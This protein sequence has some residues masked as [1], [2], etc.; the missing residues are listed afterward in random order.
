MRWSARIVAGVA[1]VL[2]AGWL[3]LR[4]QPAPFPPYPAPSAQ[5][6]RAPLPEGL[7][8]PVVRYYRALY[9]GDAV[10]LVETAVLT[11]RGT[12]RFGP[13]T[14]PA[15]FRFTHEAG[16]GYRHYI[17]ATWLGLPL[18]KVNESYL[19]GHARMELPFGTVEGPKTDAAA[20]L[21]MWAEA[22]LFPSIYVTDG[23]VRWEPIDADR[24][25][26]VVPA[27]DGEDSFDVDFDPATGLIERMTAMRY[28]DE[29]E[30]AAKLPWTAEQLP[31]GRGAARWGDHSDPWLVFTT[32]EMVLG[33][34][35]SSYIRGRGI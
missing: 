25:R 31:D 15:R 35:V 34:D 11:G 20:N 8:P 10:P 24:A 5:L 22:M 23:R 26:L 27:P 2:G 33:A 7:P 9:G 29:G 30:A 32:E 28:R 21:G 4:V 19:D 3:G 13:V 18:M 1:A 14:L 17:E 6:E 16:R 12:L